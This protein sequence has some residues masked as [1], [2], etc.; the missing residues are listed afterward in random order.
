RPAPKARRPPIVLRATRGFILPSSFHSTRFSPWWSR[1]SV[2][3]QEYAN[4]SEVC[5]L[6]DPEEMLKAAERGDAARV[7]QLLAADSTLVHAKGAHDKTP[8]HWAAEKNHGEVAELLVAAGA[9]INAEVTWGMTPLAW[10]ANMGS[11][12]VADVLLGHGAWPQLNMW[13]AAGLGMLE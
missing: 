10:A 3:L 2:S 4:M 6:V 8:L 12:E 5:Y 13:C 7:R 1:K 9:D 11:R